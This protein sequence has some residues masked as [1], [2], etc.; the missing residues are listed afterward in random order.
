MNNGWIKLHR[1]ILDNPIVTKDASYLAVWCYLLLNATHE[2]YPALFG[3]KKIML[4][5]GQLITGRRS[6]SDSLGINDSKVKRILADFES[7]QQIDRQRSNKNS[8]I[9]I[10]NWDKYQCSD[11]QSDQQVTNKRPAN[12]QQTTS[13]RPASD[14]QVTTNKNIK[15]NKNVKNEKNVKKERNTYFPADEKLNAAFADFVEMRKKIK[16]PMTDRAID[17]AIKKLEEL[18]TDST[19]SMDNDLAIQ[20]VNQ[21]VLRSWQSFYPLK[22]DSGG[23][24]R[25][26]RDLMQELMDC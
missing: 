8:L 22:D 4:Q 16:K 1:K 14:Q 17:L 24:K 19:G 18:A 2:E 25:G 23:G 5:P 7:D 21:S 26:G 10:L 11:Q 13:E 6:I 3:G 12:D 15:N 9:S 20:I